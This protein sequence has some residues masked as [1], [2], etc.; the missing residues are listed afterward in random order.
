VTS[1]APTREASD[2]P[3]AYYVRGSGLLRDV[4]AILHP[5]YTAWHLSFVVIGAL[6]GRVVNWSVLGATLIAFFLAV[7]VAAHALDELHGRPLGTSIPSGAL[8]AAAVAGLT[9]AVVIGIVGVV[10]V[11]VPLLAFVVVGTVLVL[12]YNLELFGGLL[13]NDV[14]FALS[15]GAFPVLTAAY[16]QN[17][18]I[19]V[20]A[21]VAAAVAALLSAA[22]RSLSTPARA[23][24]RRAVAVD[25]TIVYGDGTSGRLDRPA[26]LAPI[27]RALRYLSWSVVG[28]AV[29]LVLIRLGTG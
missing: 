22:Q 20:A 5:P 9:G 6:T 13:H 24:R 1:G 12:G 19:P 7:G 26:M 16:A 28:M 15:W 2:E 23:L 14:G 11:G 4:R 29:T 17:R 27:E 3:P 10:T 18:S 25:G 21:V 8:V